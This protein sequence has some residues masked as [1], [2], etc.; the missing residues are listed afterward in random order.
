MIFIMASSVIGNIVFT[1]SLPKFPTQVP[2]PLPAG[3]FFFFLQFR[4]DFSI[5]FELGS[6][7]VAQAAL[8]PP[9]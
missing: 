3:P 1:H 7:S 9:A 4:V 6:H 5:P 8:E 2:S